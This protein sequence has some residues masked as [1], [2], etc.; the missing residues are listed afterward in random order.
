[1]KVKYETNNFVVYA[2]GIRFDKFCLHLTNRDIFHNTNEKLYHFI[3][4][5]IQ[6]FS[7]K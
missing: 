7:L 2:Y 6:N 3:L 4:V 1:M 5:N